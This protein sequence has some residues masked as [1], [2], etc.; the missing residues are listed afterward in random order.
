[1][2]M[3]DDEKGVPCP[4]CRYP[5]CVQG[6]GC[7]KRQ[8]ENKVQ[9]VIHDLRKENAKLMS[10]IADVRRECERFIGEVSWVGERGSSRTARHILAVLDGKGDDGQ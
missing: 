3:L 4:K 5:D 7:A 6:K 9:K 1:M 8:R 10:Q 2:N